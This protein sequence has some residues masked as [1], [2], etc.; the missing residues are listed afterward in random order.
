MR[1]VLVFVLTIW[2]SVEAGASDQA[3]KCA[4]IKDNVRR[5]ICYDLVFQKPPDSALLAT[6]GKWRVTQE[7]SKIDDSTNVFAMLDSDD[8]YQARNKPEQK[9]GLV[10]ACRENT[11]SAY[12][13]FRETYMSDFQGGGRVTVRFDKEK[14]VTKSLS[15]SNDNHSLG[16][17]RGGTAIP[18]I[19][20]IGKSPNLIEETA[21]AAGWA[22]HAGFL[23]KTDIHLTPSLQSGSNHGKIT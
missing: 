13:A 23:P 5:L 19:K 12:F 11:T 16:M 4:T 1:I 21:M 15:E 20:S 10:L 17:W 14:A 6:T 9:V 7:T 8:S 2:G 22:Q 18:F 3:A